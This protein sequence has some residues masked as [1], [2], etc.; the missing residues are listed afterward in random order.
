M[1]L[2]QKLPVGLSLACMMMISSCSQQDVQTPA[3]ESALQKTDATM[4][5]IGE[6]VLNTPASL[7]TTNAPWGKN[8]YPE[9]WKRDV[10][11]GS[12]DVQALPAGN[13][14]L[15]SLWG[16]DSKPFVQ[17]L[18][19]IP[20]IPDMR[21]ILTVT[22]NTNATTLSGAKAI[23]KTVIT[24]LVPGQ[25]YK[26]KY[27]VACA[28]PA[29]TEQGMLPVFA[30]KVNVSLRYQNPQFGIENLSVTS[31]VGKHGIWVPVTATFTAYA[32]QVDFLFSTST[33]NA[34]KYSYAHIYVDKNAIK[35]I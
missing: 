34:G 17:A 15:E 6:D 11:A 28:V 35:K 9:F 3:P 31:L 18:E 7:A 20:G 21:G 2:V 14:S 10:S 16:D 29:E 4:R 32:T 19:K 23:G 27:Y 5:G 12:Q 26:V 24:D 13:S 33:A 25:K 1:K 22:T 8:K 30:D